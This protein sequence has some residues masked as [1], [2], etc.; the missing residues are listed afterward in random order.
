MRHLEELIFNALGPLVGGGVHPV[1]IPQ[2]ATYPCIRYA[3]ITAA[4]ESSLC[5]S[6]GLVRSSVQLDLYAQQ[7]ADVRALRESVVAVMQGFALENILV[8]E[9]EAFESDPKLF[10]RVL[11]YSMAEQEG[12]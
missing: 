11:N 12:S 9:T 5:G 7:Y 3:T 4:P 2:Q 10:R 6:S 8:S 1:V